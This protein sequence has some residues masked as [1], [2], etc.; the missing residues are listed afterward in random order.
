MRGATDAVIS[1][2]RAGAP[3]VNN[4]AIVGQYSTYSSSGGGDSFAS[5]ETFYRFDGQGRFT[6]NNNAMVSVSVRGTQDSDAPDYIDSSG[7]A[8]RFG[9]ASAGDISQSSEVGTY[10][11]LGDILIL[12]TAS[13]ASY[14]QFVDLG[15]G[16]RVDGALFMKD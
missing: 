10:A 16:L 12:H 5:S 8:V 14:H 13:G 2:A 9:G 1:S 3:Q 7:N 11:I 4:G 6:T 15:N